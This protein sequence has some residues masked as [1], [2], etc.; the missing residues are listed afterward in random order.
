VQRDV[1]NVEVFVP[2]LPFVISLSVIRLPVGGRE[3]HF[4]FFA[5]MS[6]TSNTSRY[7]LEAN[8]AVEQ[9]A[10]TPGCRE[11]GVLVE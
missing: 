4:I 10:V 6:E 2:S 1:P 11:T 7:V 8:S 5:D 9:W 3:E